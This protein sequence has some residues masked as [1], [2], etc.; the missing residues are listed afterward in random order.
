[1]PTS[2][3]ARTS[4]MRSDAKA[5]QSARTPCSSVSSDRRRYRASSTRS[6]TGSLLQVILSRSS[7]GF[8]IR[9]PTAPLVTYAQADDDAELE[10]E[11]ADRPRHER[12]R[13]EVGLTGR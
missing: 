5:S 6:A 12:D 11:L 3:P 7:E 8:L 1:M 2:R 10:E 4:A 13:Q 9:P